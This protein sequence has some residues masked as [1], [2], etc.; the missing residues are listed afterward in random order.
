MFKNQTIRVGRVVA[1]GVLSLGFV[2]SAATIASASDHGRHHS[3]HHGGGHSS[4]KALRVEGVVTA[5]S[6]AVGSTNG[7]IS[8]MTEHSV[9]ATTFTVTSATTIVGG[10]TPTTLPAINDNVDLVLS[11]TVTTPPTLT[12]IKI[13]SEKSDDHGDEGHS[14]NDHDGAKSSGSFESGAQVSHSH[15]AEGGSG[16]G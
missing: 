1:A 9:V 12:S 13:D 8:V 3:E 6:A 7:S 4:A 5:F 16:R 10:L 14:K 11:S 2:A 15:D